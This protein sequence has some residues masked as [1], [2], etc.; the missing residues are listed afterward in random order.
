MKSRKGKNLPA[1]SCLGFDKLSLAA[2]GIN[3]MNAF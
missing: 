3:K 2:S 1:E